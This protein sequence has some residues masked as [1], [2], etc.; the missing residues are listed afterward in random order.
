M[1]P[2]KLILPAEVS[3]FPVVNTNSV[4]VSPL[5]LNALPTNI[6]SFTDASSKYPVPLALMFPLGQGPLAVIFPTNVC[7][8]L[9]YRPKEVEPDVIISPVA[10]ISVTFNP[11]PPIPPTDN[12]L[13]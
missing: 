13:A 4:F 3:I 11:L 2:T 7:V 12:D 5:C 6:S 8:L 9:V 10:V 1:S